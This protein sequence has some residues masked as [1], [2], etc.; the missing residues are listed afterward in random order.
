[1][2]IRNALIVSV[3]AIIVIVVGCYGVVRYMTTAPDSLFETAQL[4][5]AREDV[6][7]RDRLKDHVA[8]LSASERNIAHYDGLERAAQY[9]E[10]ALQ[11]F[12]YTIGRQAY[13][14]QGKQVRNIDAVIEAASGEASPETVVIGAHYDSAIGTPGANANATGTA[15]VLELGRQLRDLKDRCRKRIRFA[16]FATKEPP[17]FQTADMGSLRYAKALAARGE[18]VAAMYSL[19]SLG[20]YSNERGSQR[21]APLLDL[22]LPDRG[23]FVAFVGLLGSRPLASESLRLFRSYTQ[24]PSFMGVGPG[25][26]PGIAGSDHWAFAEQGFPAILVTDTAQ[27]RYPHHHRPTDT[28]DKLDIAKLTRVVKTIEGIIRDNAQCRV[29]E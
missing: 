27:L 9:L 26:I 3:Q 22:V 29:S 4:S 15:A 19:D 12:G 10:A 14:V 8:T 5:F 7:L 17:H 1:M 28:P 24:F 11:N 20:Y 2:A 6:L 13:E 16:F 21:Y 23:D 18:R 25:L